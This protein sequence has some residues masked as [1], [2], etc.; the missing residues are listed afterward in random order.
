MFLNSFFLDVVKMHWETLG[1]FVSGAVLQEHFTLLN[2]VVAHL[3]IPSGFLS[4]SNLFFS[5][6]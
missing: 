2:M 4:Y 6:F 5:E 1:L 3:G